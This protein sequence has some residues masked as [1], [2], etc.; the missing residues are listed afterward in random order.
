MQIIPDELVERAAKG[1]VSY[2]EINEILEKLK[3]AKID[4]RPRGGTRNPRDGSGSPLDQVHAYSLNQQEQK[5]SQQPERR[6]RRN[7]QS[8]SETPRT[9]P[10]S[11][12]PERKLGFY[13]AFVDSLN[14]NLTRYASIAETVQGITKKELNGE[15]IFAEDAEGRLII[16]LKFVPGNRSN[17]LSP[18]LHGKLPEKAFCGFQVLRDICFGGATDRSGNREL[19]QYGQ[20]YKDEHNSNWCIANQTVEARKEGNSGKKKGRGGSQHS[21]ANASLAETAL[22]DDDVPLLTSASVR[23]N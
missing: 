5:R 16:P 3:V 7:D 20:K 2:D 10:R 13:K 4:G 21:R 18:A 6:G 11:Q 8:D 17:R 15:A 12:S 1:L 19:T 14:G 22:D 23:F 9:R